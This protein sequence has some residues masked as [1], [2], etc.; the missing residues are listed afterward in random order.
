M[1]TVYGWVLLFMLAILAFTQLTGIHAR[2]LLTA[3]FLGFWAWAVIQALLD[4]VWVTAGMLCC[5]IAPLSFVLPVLYGPNFIIVPLCLIF[6]TMGFLT[7]HLLM[8]FKRGKT[9]AP[10]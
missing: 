9:I 7:K 4:G 3:L 1:R 2:V 8:Q 10:R 5:L 6:A